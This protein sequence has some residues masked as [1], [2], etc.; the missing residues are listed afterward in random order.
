MTVWSCTAKSVAPERPVTAYMIVHPQCSTVLSWKNCDSGPS[1]TPSIVNRIAIWLS[2]VFASSEYVTVAIKRMTLPELPTTIPVW[3]SPVILTQLAVD[4][5][6]AELERF[7]RR[8][9]I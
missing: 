9:D 8:S 6:V 4:V 7:R 5:W 3:L 2:A 1:A